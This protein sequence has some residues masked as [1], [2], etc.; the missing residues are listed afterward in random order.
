MCYMCCDFVPF[1]CLFL[2]NLELGE[3]LDTLL[4]TTTGSLNINDVESDSLGERTALTESHEVTL[5]DTE[6][7]RQVSWEILVTLLETVVL[8]DVVKVITTH[9]NGTAHL[10]G[11]DN[12]L[13]DASTDS[14]VT[15][16]WALLVNISTI[17]SLLWGTETKTDVAEITHMAL[18]DLT[19]KDALAAKLDS[20]LLLE[21]VLFLCCWR[22][23]REEKRRE[24]KRREEKGRE[25]KGREEKGRE[26]RSVS[27]GDKECVMKRVLL[28]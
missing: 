1:V 3:E 9:D 26:E 8:G 22:V 11:L 19:S 27:K 15:G 24:E 23:R 14:N 4:L 5:V 13:Q 21:S 20:R 12:T 10:V 28:H 17:D 2:F 6:A 25:E 16:E 7:R 18:L